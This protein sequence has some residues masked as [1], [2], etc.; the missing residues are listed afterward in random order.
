MKTVI[1]ISRKAQ[2]QP[3][4]VGSRPSPDQVKRALNVAT[5]EFEA[6]YQVSGNKRVECSYEH[7]PEQV[8]TAYLAEVERQ[9]AIAAMYVNR[10][11]FR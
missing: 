6:S 11:T 2:A 1:K 9:R 4:V 5:Q 10:N 7:V 8:N 3:T